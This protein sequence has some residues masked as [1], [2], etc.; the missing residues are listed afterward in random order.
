MSSESASSRSFLDRLTIMAGC[1]IFPL[2]SLT[3][4]AILASGEELAAQLH[5]HTYV[6]LLQ[7][8]GDAAGRAGR[9]H[10]PGQMLPAVQPALFREQDGA[11]DAARDPAHQ[12][13]V[14]GVAA[15][16]RTLHFLLQ[17]CILSSSKQFE[18]LQWS[19]HGQA[20]LFGVTSGRREVVALPKGHVLGRRCST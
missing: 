8:A 5:L 2:M 15:F 18:L 1:H 17:G 14:C 12:P 7:G 20:H 10:A 6:I 16:M 4:H 3:T 19:C 9:P 11:G 13:A